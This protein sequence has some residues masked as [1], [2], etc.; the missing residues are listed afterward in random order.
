MV[1]EPL[2]EFF[3]KLENVDLMMGVQMPHHGMSVRLKDDKWTD[4]ELEENG[5]VS[6]TVT[7]GSRKNFKVIPAV[8][9]ACYETSEA[10]K[11][12]KELDGRS[13]EETGK[14][15]RSSVDEGA[16]KSRG[17]GRPKI[18]SPV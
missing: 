18:K 6:V 1:M 3:M 15:G 13:A 2:P 5:S 14:E 12:A 9:V 7:A 17:R 16:A 4:L 11:I 10:A 8:N